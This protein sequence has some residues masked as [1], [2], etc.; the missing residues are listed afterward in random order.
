MKPEETLDFHL[1]WAWHNI[2]RLYNAEAAQHGITMSTGFVLLSIDQKDGTPSTKLGPKMGME[3]RSLTRTLKSMEDDKLIYRK[4]D[5][6]DKRS[7]RIY[8]T[9]KGKKKR[10]I[11]KTKV[12]Y[13][14]EVLQKKLGRK[15]VTEFFDTMN[16][17]NQLIEGFNFN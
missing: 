2:A 4:S 14:N 15:K 7:V 9:E 12:V 11:A 13:F 5:K 17:M 10:D 16:E 3:P 8:L 1:R 6:S